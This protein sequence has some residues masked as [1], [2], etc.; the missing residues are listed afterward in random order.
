MASAPTCPGCGQPLCP[1]RRS[2]SG[3]ARPLPVVFGAAAGLAVP[4]ARL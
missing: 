3:G 1:G 2:G 4:A